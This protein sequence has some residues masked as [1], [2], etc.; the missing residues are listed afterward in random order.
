LKDRLKPFS[1]DS[2]TGSDLNT[3]QVSWWR[4]EGRKKKEEEGRRWKMEEEG[5][6]KS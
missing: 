4:K 2:T 3:V 6:R 1:K 5:R